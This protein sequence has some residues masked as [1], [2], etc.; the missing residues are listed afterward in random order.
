MNP[1]SRIRSWVYD[2]LAPDIHYEHTPDP[3]I[4]VH[5]EETKRVVMR[6]E[7]ALARHQKLMPSERRY[8]ERLGGLNER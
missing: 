4:A 2:A 3:D 7:L 6:A 5:R 8:N 1:F